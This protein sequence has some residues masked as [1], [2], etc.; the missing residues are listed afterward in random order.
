L[1]KRKGLAQVLC[2]PFRGVMRGDVKVHHPTAVMRQ[3]QKHVS[4]LD[5]DRRHGE[6]VDR[7]QILDVIIQ[8]SAPGL[9]G[10]L[11]K[12]ANEGRPFPG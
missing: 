2:R 4:H 7:Y 11:E 3:H 8:E 6:E 5:S 1:I 12:L 9:R 10:P